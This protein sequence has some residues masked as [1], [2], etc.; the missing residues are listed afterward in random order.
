MSNFIVTYSDKL[1][2]IYIRS[3]VIVVVTNDD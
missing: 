3:I 1:Y 2:K